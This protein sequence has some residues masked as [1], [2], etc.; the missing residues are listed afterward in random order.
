MSNLVF[1]YDQQFQK[2]LTPESHPE[3][4]NRL[5]AIENALHRSEL[6]KQV[7]RA[8]PRTATGDEL[9]TVHNAG[10][11]EDMERKGKQARDKNETIQLDA[12]AETFMS[13]ES[14]DTAKL[15]A[16]AGI[17]AIESVLKGNAPASFVAV[18]PPGHHALADKPMGFCIFNNIAI[19]ARYAQE[20]LGAKKVMIIDW[21]VHHG[22]GT[23]DIFFDDPSVCFVS[24]HQYPFWPPN[25]GW[26]TEDGVGEGK[27]Y[28]INIPLPAGTGD[29]GYIKAWDAIVNPIAEEYKPDLILLSAGYDAH[30]FDPLGQQQITTSGYYLLSTRL[31]DLADRTGA[32]LSGFLEGG[33]NTRTLADSVVTTMSVL[34]AD[35]A[36]ARREVKP[37]G[38]K[39]G[40]EIAAET[41]DRN[42]VLVDERIDTLRK[43]FS[44]YWK[45]L[46]TN[47][48]V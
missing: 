39:Y 30:Q 15:A 10:Y 28:N 35:N 18:R 24:F 38:E 47:V 45:S 17:V 32:K 42:P 43:H 22:N 3:S 46:R 16:G 1:V 25:V 31:A 36:A 2:H 40:G 11:I 14:Y 12:A 4:P 23:Q 37:F 7:R 48:M 44:K 33:Y 20:Y 8:E 29:R 21:D 6:I 9:A 19:G 26:Y 41:D 27:G 34:N 13:P 5:A